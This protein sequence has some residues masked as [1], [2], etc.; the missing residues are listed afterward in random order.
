MSHFYGKLKGN[1][2]EATRCGTKDSG[3]VTDTAGW[4]GSI[5]TR[6][7]HDEELKRDRYQVWLTPWQ[8]SGG[9]QRML[10]EGFLEANDGH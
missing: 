6:V 9:A 3:M 7:W 4:G 1:R 5:L 10:S 2:G 8:C